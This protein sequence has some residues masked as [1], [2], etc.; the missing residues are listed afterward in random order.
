MKDKSE[1]RPST[2]SPEQKVPVTYQAQGGPLHAV[3]HPVRVQPLDAPPKIARSKSIHPRRL[4]P[5]VAEGQER[6]FHSL[7]TRANVHRPEDAG[8]DIQIVLN[9]PLT[10][11]AQTGNAGNVGEPSVSVNGEVVFYTGNWYAAVSTDG[12]NTFKFIDPNSMAQPTDP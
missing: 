6:G 3:A 10:Q 2:K 5:F 11:L 8:Q 7:N 12:G 9:T 1:K 4:L